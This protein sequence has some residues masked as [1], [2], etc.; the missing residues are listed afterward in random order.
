MSS[1]C[2][3]SIISRYIQI[4]RLENNQTS[5]FPIRHLIAVSRVC[6]FV[7]WRGGVTLVWRSARR[8]T[9][10]CWLRASS[11]APADYFIPPKL[12]LLAPAVS[13]TSPSHL[14]SIFNRAIIVKYKSCAF[15]ASWF[16]PTH[17]PIT[18][19]CCNSHCT[20][21]QPSI[22]PYLHRSTLLG[23]L[24]ELLQTWR[25]SPKKKSRPITSKLRSCLMLEIP[26]KPNF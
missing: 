14:Q 11:P 24:F 7:G 4:R 22:S 16:L 21:T 25:F 17:T 6:Y 8:S 18:L 13:A 12:W 26:K 2:S 5:V 10:N 19:H 1:I 9:R 20:Y 23:H 15:P 3:H